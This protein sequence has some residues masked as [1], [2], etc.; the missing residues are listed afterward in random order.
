MKPSNPYVGPVSFQ[1]KDEHKF[2]GREREAGDLASLVAA[3]PATLFYATSGAGKTSILNA[4]L[5][6]A[7]ALRGASVL[8]PVRVIRPAEALQ[9]VQP[10]NIFAFNVLRGIAPKTID[11]SRLSLADYLFSIRA[12]NDDD[13]IRPLRVLILDQFEELFTSFPERWEERR[14]FFEQI[15]EA[16][17]N[18]GR[19]RVLFSM[20]EE[21][22]AKLDSY[23]EELPDALR[24]RLRL[25]RLGP[26]A[27][28]KAIAR[29][30][31]LTGISYADGVAE[32]LVEKL[33]RRNDGLA[34]EFV[35]P[36]HLQIVCS[37]LWQELPDGTPVISKDMADTRGDVERA[38]A[39]YYDRSIQEIAKA[40]GVVEGLL[41]TGFE[42]AFITDGNRAP[43]RLIKGRSAGDLDGK[44]IPDLEKF[45]L[46]RLTFSGD[47]ASWYELS[48][49]RFIAPILQSNNE[50]RERD[51]SSFFY[52]RIEGQA[53][54]WERS[55]ARVR[56]KLRL[57]GVDLATAREWIAEGKRTGYG[58]S[59]LARRLIGESAEFHGRRLRTILIAVAVVALAL[60][61][62]AAIKLRD[63]DRVTR[64]RAE[65]E[66]EAEIARSML[67]EAKIHD[68]L[69]WALRATSKSSGAEIPEA[70]KRVLID[71]VSASSQGVWLPRRGESLQA[72]RFSPNGNRV[73]TLTPRELCVWMTRDG[74]KES[75]SAPS[76]VGST[77]RAAE[78]APG[79]KFLW[80]TASAD[81]PS[82][83]NPQVQYILYRIPSM[84]LLFQ[85]TLT[86]GVTA[87]LH[88]TDSTLSFAT[89]KVSDPYALAFSYDGKQLFVAEGNQL[90]I[91]T[92]PA[93]A[94]VRSIPIGN[95]VVSNIEL[96]Q[97][98]RYAA[99]KV[100]PFKR[101]LLLD[102]RGA[103]TLR[104]KD[105]SPESR[106]VFLDAGRT[107]ALIGGGKIRYFRTADGIPPK[108]DTNVPAEGKTFIRRGGLIKARP[109]ETNT[110]V[111]VYRLA[112][113]DTPSSKLLPTAIIDDLDLSAEGRYLVTSSGSMARIWDFKA[114]DVPLNFASMGTLKALG[115]QELKRLGPVVPQLKEVCTSQ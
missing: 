59:E 46:I 21:F 82:E 107:L 91:L 61:V 50:W 70:A 42:R 108:K 18:D 56:P 71:A 110:V 72:V 98:G 48:H 102:L 94:V 81:A 76:D 7:L 8:G 38:L 41:R 13:A 16:L 83:L 64:E 27:A 49:D 14:Q 112:S 60:V 1:T 9:E 45:H 66:A 95:H 114:T 55:D 52:A 69:S 12:S 73:M 80:A 43:V 88:R 103:R 17:K 85:R 87:I 34:T 65:A 6:P 115:C 105:V 58:P 113:S 51:P 2:F 19:L 30:L 100:S 106:P 25:E 24:M 47:D 32:G 3:Y 35:E 5:L 31:D 74:G 86:A 99:L 4:K 53:L 109:K 62:V 75:C 39:N 104:L 20:R 54:D 29:P 33:R 89:T 111:E 28:L 10:A 67:D 78:F 26:D 63:F 11:I 84:K 22:T 40:H 36:L 44:Y 93:L 79:G 96:S 68:A 37:R 23:A 90:T 92:V 77:W 15:G 101:L 97:D 57:S